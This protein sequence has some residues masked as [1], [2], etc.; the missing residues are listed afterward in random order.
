MTTTSQAAL[1]YHEELSD[2]ETR[3]LICELCNHFYHLGWVSGTGGGMSIRRGDQIYMAPSGVQK[4]RIQPADIFVLDL[5]GEVL[6]GPQNPKLKVSACRPLFLHAFQ[7]R[8]AGAVL[9]SHSIHAMLATLIYGDEFEI[10]NLEM[11]KGIQ[12]VGCFDTH[13]VPIIQN[14]PYEEELTD[15]LG[16]AMDAYPDSQA[17]LVKGHGVYVWG[18]T[19]VKAKTQAECYDYLFQAAVEIQRLGLNPRTGGQT[20]S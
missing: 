20:L 14:T 17:I 15:S 1:S 12:N 11:L 8:G 4:E 16:E 5:N 9:H 19:W 18:P 6:Q 3:E 13:K 2:R 10:A 7:K